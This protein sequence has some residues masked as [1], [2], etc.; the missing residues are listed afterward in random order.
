M[1]P[2]VPLRFYATYPL[3]LVHDDPRLR[4]RPLPRKL[5]EAQLASGADEIDDFT[6]RASFAAISRSHL[7]WYYAKRIIIGKGQGIPQRPRKLCNA[8]SA[9]RPASM[10]L[11]R[12]SD[13]TVPP[14]SFGLT[15][16]RPPPPLPLPFE[17]FCWWIFLTFIRSS[18]GP[19]RHSYSFLHLSCD[20]LELILSSYL[21][22]VNRSPLTSTV[23]PCSNRRIYRS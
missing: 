10:T 16:I 4:P 20:T 18:S 11:N 3:R 19:G 14:T 9:S 7:W 13:P 21:Y 6:L 8:E 23:F 1:Y 15:Q 12:L 22:Y 5:R 17:S 2:R